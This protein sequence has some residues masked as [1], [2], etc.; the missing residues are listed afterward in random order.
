MFTQS[1][2]IGWAIVESGYV[3]AILP[4]WWIL[5]YKLQSPN[6]LI[7]KEMQ[8]RNFILSSVAG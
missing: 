5:Y 7:P 1:F 3:Q 4:G 6:Y 8:G 2:Q